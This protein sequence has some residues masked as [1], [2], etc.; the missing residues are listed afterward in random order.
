M[1][2]YTKF[3]KYAKILIAISVFLLFCLIFLY[4]LIKKDTVVRIAL[5]SVEKGASE[6]TKMSNPNFHG[7]DA[8]N[9]PYNVTAKTATQ[10]DEDNVTL[11]SLNGDIALKDGKW[12]SVTALTGKLK[13]K[14]HLLD[15]SGSVDIFSDDGY[16]MRTELLNI[17]I[18]KKIA[19]TNLEVKGQGLLGK[20]SS[21]GAVFNGITKVSKFNDK[22]FVTIYLPHKEPSQAKPTETKNKKSQAKSKSSPK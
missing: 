9:Q 18:S 12:L 3:V 4:P 20:I 16:E 14:E 13:V 8:N 15:L 19:T 17:D 21:Q 10:L 2:F 1:S 5:T 22:V 7:F 6:P 11:E